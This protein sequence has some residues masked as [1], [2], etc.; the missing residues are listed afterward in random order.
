M[1]IRG[2]SSVHIFS[3]KLRLT[4]K[5]YFRFIYTKLQIWKLYDT[6][7]IGRIPTYQFS[8]GL[9]LPV[10][11]QRGR[12]FLS[13]LRKLRFD[14]FKSLCLVIMLEVSIEKV[15]LSF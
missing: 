9:F 4:Y 8:S 7:K 6:N 13:Y 2:F 14:S 1:R 10:R 11:K 12:V 3:K 15:F 5:M